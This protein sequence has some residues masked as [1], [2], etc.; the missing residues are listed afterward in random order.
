MYAFGS[1]TGR[2]RTYLEEQ[3]GTRF[4]GRIRPLYPDFVDRVRRMLRRI[5]GLSV[6]AG[7]RLA[8]EQVEQIVEEEWPS[9]HRA[10]HPHVDLYRPR[11][12]Q[13]SHMLAPNF[14]AHNLRP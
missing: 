13:W 4:H 8:H 6:E 5:V 3:L 7:G 9:E 11:P 10:D 14:D 12:R 1:E 2:V